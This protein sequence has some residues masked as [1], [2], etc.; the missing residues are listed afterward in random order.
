MS[1]NTANDVP[2]LA[3]CSPAEPSAAGAL[4]AQPVRHR[5]LSA[6]KIQVMQRICD[7]IAQGRSLADICRQD[8]SPEYCTVARWLGKYEDFRE[9]YNRARESQADV[10]ADEIVSIA[11][12]MPTITVQTRHGEHQSID[13]A[14]IQRNRLRVDARKWV[15]AKLK[16]KVYG[17]ALQHTGPDGGPMQVMVAAW[18]SPQPKAEPDSE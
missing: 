16:P 10:L 4:P 7:E 15:A 9:S 8:W 1:D 3:T 5:K 2:A 6:Y 11:D 13:M 17:D 18:M 12:E 14:A